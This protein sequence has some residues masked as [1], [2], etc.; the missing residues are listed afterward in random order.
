MLSAGPG[1]D[2]ITGQYIQ[3]AKI[4]CQILATAYALFRLVIIILDLVCF[5]LRF[6]YET[7]FF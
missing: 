1:V 2:L 5:N 6:K 7:Q 4:F 3:S